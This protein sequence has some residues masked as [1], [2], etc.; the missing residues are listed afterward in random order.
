M[1]AG[2]AVLGVVTA[3]IASWFVENL[4][5]AGERV[6][7]EVEEIEESGERT[8]VTLAAVLVELREIS[9]RLDALERDRHPS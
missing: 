2:I 4:R 9:A 5:Q 6:A 1:V 7:D 8:A 3:S